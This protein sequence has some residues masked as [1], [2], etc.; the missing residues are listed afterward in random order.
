MLLWRKGDASVARRRFDD[1]LVL[2]EFAAFL[3]VPD[4]VGADA[5]LDAVSRVSTSILAST[6][7]AVLGD[8]V[9][10]DQRGVADREAVVV[11][12]GD[13]TLRGG[14]DPKNQPSDGHS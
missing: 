14:V 9:Q 12:D 10:L 8:V 2:G 6:V 4:H 1:H 13:M 7:P 5:A 11:V 3:G